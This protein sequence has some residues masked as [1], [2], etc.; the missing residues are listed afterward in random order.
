MK[1][2]QRASNL[3]THTAKIIAALCL[4]SGQSTFASDWPIDDSLG[5]ET[6]PANVAEQSEG[7]PKFR[8]ACVVQ[9]EI[10]LPSRMKIPLR[11]LVYAR[12][13][14]TWKN[15]TNELVTETFTPGMRHL[16]RYQLSSSI[17]Y[18]Y[19]FDPIAMSDNERI[20]FKYGSLDN[21]MDGFM[22][23]IFNRRTRQF[24]T[25]G[26]RFLR[27]PRVEISPD[28][29]YVTY[30]RGG[31]MYGALPGASEITELWL[32]D[33]KL[34]TGRR[35]THSK[36]PYY[37][38]DWL[39][40]KRSGPKIY[41]LHYT[42]YVEIRTSKDEDEITRLERFIFDTATR[43]SRPNLGNTLFLNPSPD[44]QHLLYATA[45]DPTEDYYGMK[46]YSVRFKKVGDITNQTIFLPREFADDLTYLPTGG[47][48]WTPDSKR[49]FCIF[50]QRSK[51]KELENDEVSNTF[52]GVT[53]SIAG[54]RTKPL[55]AL[56]TVTVISHLFPSYI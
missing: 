5:P 55:R 23:G 6:E 15:H 56:N 3:T 11:T 17:N 19:L 22:M 50:Q 8:C 12:Q 31:G 27:I 40:T 20:L 1:I 29:R 7:T 35:L 18:G 21:S 26:S 47:N 32:F 46:T 54:G 49:L 38:T 51:D 2:L 24:Q 13:L 39:P 44:G 33:S 53:T 52:V 16:T 9:Q 48:F 25:V 45:S 4:F 36:S 37:S 34:G 41:D 43:K 42:R 30:V 14:G 28:G 10:A